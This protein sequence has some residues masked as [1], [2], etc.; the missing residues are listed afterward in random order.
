M[1]LAGYALGISLVLNLI[2]L[3]ITLLF[4][5]LG[6]S[7]IHRYWENYHGSM[8]WATYR[9]TLRPLS[10]R[11]VPAPDHWLPVLRYG[12]NL[13]SRVG[14]RTQVLQ[15]EIPAADLGTVLYD[16][17][18]FA[19]FS[20]DSVYYAWV[21]LRGNH[22]SFPFGARPVFVI[23]NYQAAPAA[24]ASVPD[25]PVQGQW[26]RP[27]VVYAWAALTTWLWLLA[28]AIAV[29]ALPDYRRL[30]DR[31]GALGLVMVFGAAAGYVDWLDYTTGDEWPIF[32]P[33]VL[34][35]LLAGYGYQLQ[36]PPESEEGSEDGE[37]VSDL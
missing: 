15:S 29:S 33:L 10:A 24:G 26:R 31:L 13:E 16:T 11:P 18:N 35:A 30:A 25:W 6:L 14:L 1:K 20:P 34:L 8:S 32:W 36:Q 37:A 9:V 21:G 7:R 17:T 3:P 23:T 12:F 22:L 27:L 19:P 4:D 5:G 28:A 2:I